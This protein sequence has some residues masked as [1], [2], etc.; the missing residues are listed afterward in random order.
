MLILWEMVVNIQAKINLAMMYSFTGQFDLAKD[1]I[2]L[3]WMSLY[4][5]V[6]FFGIYDSYR[7]TVDLNMIY[8]LAEREKSNPSFFFNQLSGNLNYL[9]KR[10][11]WLAV[12]G[13]ILVPGMGQLY[14]HS[15][16][17]G[18]DI[19]AFLSTLKS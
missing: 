11:P 14:I 4:A 12:I 2:D 3:R 18:L 19:N 13:S 10:S 15:P 16:T 1:V 9:D 5:P 17:F 6:F 8:I 7:T